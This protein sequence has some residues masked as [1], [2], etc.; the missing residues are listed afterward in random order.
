VKEK[1]GIGIL[2]MLSTGETA[3]QSKRPSLENPMS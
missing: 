1:S 3:T 2:P